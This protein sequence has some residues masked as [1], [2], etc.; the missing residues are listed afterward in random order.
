[1]VTDRELL[2]E[3]FMEAAPVAV[4]QVEAGEV[5]DVTTTALAVAQ[6]CI[7]EA[8]AGCVVRSRFVTVT[9]AISIMG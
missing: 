3:L 2:G 4:V 1:M 9:E 7:L 8:A 6:Y 5:V